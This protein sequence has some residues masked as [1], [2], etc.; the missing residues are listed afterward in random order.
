[1]LCQGS[2]PA[3]PHSIPPLQ[4]A[5]L[6]RYA[7]PGAQLRAKDAPFRNSSAGERSPSASPGC[8]GRTGKRYDS[9][10]DKLRQPG[11]SLDAALTATLLLHQASRA[12]DDPLRSTSPRYPSCSCNDCSGHRVLGDRPK[13][14]P[15]TAHLLR[16][17]P[18]P[19]CAPRVVRLCLSHALCSL[20]E[21][22]RLAWTRSH[23]RLQMPALRSRQP[24]RLPRALTG[25]TCRSIA[26]VLGGSR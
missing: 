24:Q 23:G 7:K 10:Q 21:P 16:A 9:S 3:L 2:K 15:S 12:N 25:V 14:A 17:D 6:V 26:L 20:R 1:M 22:H 5:V 19:R 18:R 8:P 13:A 4:T 11:Q